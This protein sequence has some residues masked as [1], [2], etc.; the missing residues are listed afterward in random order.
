[1]VSIEQTTR[2]YHGRKAATYES[3]RTRQQRWSW[4]SEHAERMLRALSPIDVLDCPVGT[5]RFLR[6]YKRLGVASVLGVDASSSMLALARRRTQ[7]SDR[8]VS[9]VEGDATALRSEDRSWDVAVCV[10]FL[11]LIDEDAMRRVVRE[12]CRVAHRAVILTVRLG[13][14]Y[15]PKSNTATHDRRKFHALVRRLGFDATEAVQFREAGWYMITLT[16]RRT[17]R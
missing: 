17:K 1:M 13:E 7:V 16:R 14:V 5:G 2:K 8:H 12:L 10:R 9:L 3:I 11:D 6:L 4:E 15:V